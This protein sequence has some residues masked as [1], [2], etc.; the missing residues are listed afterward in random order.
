MIHF[1]FYSCYQK[2]EKN[3]FLIL[4]IFAYNSAPGNPIALR[5]H[6]FDACGS[7]ES[8]SVDRTRISLPGAKL[9]KK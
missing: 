1:V 4:N 9:W 7:H 5:P 6:A 2:E 3:A 8:L